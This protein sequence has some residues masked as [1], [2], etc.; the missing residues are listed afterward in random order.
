MK[1]TADKISELGL[2]PGIWFMP[3]AGN[4][5]GSRTSRTTRTGSPRGRD[6]KPFETDWGGT[7]LDMTH[8][9]AREYLQG[10]VRAH[11]PRLGLPGLQDGRLLDRQR[12]AADLRERRLPGRRASARP[13]S[14][15]RT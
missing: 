11:R 6:G 4:C 3:F 15:T 5:R 8:P 7:C 12:H 13:A 10:I 14:P 9:G 1:A 2:T